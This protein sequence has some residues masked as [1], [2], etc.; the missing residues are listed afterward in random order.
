[1]K[2]LTFVSIPE[3][4]QKPII[5]TRDKSIRLAK[6]T[7][8]SLITFFAITVLSILLFIFGTMIVN[9]QVSTDARYRAIDSRTN[10]IFMLSVCESFQ[11]QSR[12]NNHADYA[13][14]RLA[15]PKHV[16][17]FDKASL[18]ILKGKLIS[19]KEV[20][21]QK[22]TCP[23]LLKSAQDMAEKQYVKAQQVSK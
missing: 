12:I 10:Q 2:F 8:Y 14:I 20:T 11:R 22:D 9:S 19:S 15:P 17:S 21:S 1:M 5:S 7:A 16:T 4:I 23:D 18:H 3:E 6:A 13:V